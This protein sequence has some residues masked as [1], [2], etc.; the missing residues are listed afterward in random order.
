MILFKSFRNIFAIEELRNKIL[1]TLGVLVITRLGRLIPVIG[2]DT[3]LLGRMIQESKGVGGLLSYLDLFSGGALSQGTLF[4][5]GISPYITAS[6]MMQL[7][8][9]T[10]PRFEQ[11]LKEGDYG[12][13]IM[14]QYTRYLTLVLSIVYSSSYALVLE[15][16]GLVLDPGIGFKLIFIVSLAAGAMF[17]MW[18]G[19]QISLY[20]IGN[21]SSVIIC[22]SIVAR[23][24]SDIGRTL[25][26]IKE[27][28]VDP[29][30]AILALII[31]ILIAACIIF[32]EKGERK[33][34]V[35]YARR[36]IGQRMYAGQSTYLPFK[37]NPT[38]VMP[39][40]FASSFLNFPR[41]VFGMLAEYF[42]QLR[43]LADFISQPF[44]MNI[45]LFVLIV[46]FSFAYTA[47]IFNPEEL[48]DNMKKNGG[49]IP[50]IRPGRKTAEFFDY[51]LTRIGLV[52]AIYLGCLA[53][54]PDL[55][56]AYMGLPIALG[57]T[58]ILIAV[59]VALDVSAQME[60]YLI[61]HRYE[62]FLDTGRLRAR[63]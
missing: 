51:I 1:F 54:L 63:G 19:D 31:F 11:L 45:M 4:A 22:S 44:V 52:G 13:K 17:V 50:G 24:P 18:L 62:G 48:A 16:K 40:I 59:G 12:R 37:I 41:L 14:N 29:F 60:T 56:T 58:S 32:L 39:V 3:A 9:M 21:G 30:I 33:I 7:L 49:F 38:G 20:G 61:E 2:V 42:K 25:T 47:L 5:L 8:G 23:F 27:G 28:Q 46:F 15:A 10:I 26:F 6:I 53:V 34:S 35:Q 36:I 55:F 57:G 43:F